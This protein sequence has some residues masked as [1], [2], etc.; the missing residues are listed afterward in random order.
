MTF[1]DTVAPTENGRPQHCICHPSTHTRVTWPLWP[2]VSEG[3]Q[4]LKVADLLMTEAHDVLA[5]RA[6]P[7][8][9]AGSR[10]KL[11][12]SAVL[13]ASGSCGGRGAR[14]SR[15]GDTVRVRGAGLGGAG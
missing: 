8:P 13:R 11:A 1:H 12:Q 2:V 7:R 6:R 14:P 10:S 9:V 15:I 3:G 4:L 5:V